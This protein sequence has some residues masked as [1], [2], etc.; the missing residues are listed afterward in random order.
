MTI[1]SPCVNICK[2]DA[3][4]GLCQ[5]CLR[6]IDE[7]TV[8]SRLDDAGRQHILANVARRRGEPAPRENKLRS[9]GNAK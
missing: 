6:T 5:G 3:K 2:M 1:P 7:I 9:N 8:W 4:S